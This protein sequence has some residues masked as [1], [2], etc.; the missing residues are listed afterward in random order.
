MPE[1]L[2]LGGLQ[3]APRAGDD[4]AWVS[5]GAGL[6]RCIPLRWASATSGIAK[7]V[8]E[9]STFH[10]ALKEMDRDAPSVPRLL[11]QRTARRATCCSTR[12]HFDC[13]DYGYDDLFD[14]TYV[15]LDHHVSL[16]GSA[17]PR[18]R[19][20]RARSSRLWGRKLLLL[21]LLVL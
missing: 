13:N 10:L 11:L 3:R 4:R 20:P 2:F 18:P 12:Y 7:L 6:A 5:A 1:V 21:L 17:P 14:S 9:G 16:S 15:D 19:R 8:D